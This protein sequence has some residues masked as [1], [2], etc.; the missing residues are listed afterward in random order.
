MNCVPCFEGKHT[1]RFPGSLASTVRLVRLH[2]ET[3]GK[4]DVESEEG[5]R[6]FLTVVDEYSRCT[7]V[8]PL[9]SKGEASESL[10][11]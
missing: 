4:D 6:Y 8:C 3:N 7:Q 10:L 11:A 2:W 9:K 5:Q 1:R